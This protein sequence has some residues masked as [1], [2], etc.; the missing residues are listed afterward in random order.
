MKRRTMFVASWKANMGT[1]EQAT[2]FFDE[3]APIS[4]SF[5]HEVILCPNHVFIDMASKKMP[6]TMQLGAQD[7]SATGNGPHTGE[8]TASVLSNFGVK[9]AIVGHMERRIA[10]EDDKAVNKKIKQCLA[11]GIR[12]IITVGETLAE[13]ER[14]M[15]RVILERQ[16][17]EALDG[18]REYDK[19]IFC[20]QPSWSIGTGHFTSGDYTNLIMDFMRKHIQKLT[21]Q[22]MAGNVPMLYGGGV[23]V[24]NAREYLEQ[25]EVDG[26]MWG[27]NTTTAKGLADMVNLQFVPKGRL[28]S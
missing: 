14:N 9:Y 26:L 8:I 20:Y 12:P 17:M 15:T 22:P 28:Q 13:Y 3:I 5:M 25:P 24:N 21:G 4:A 18:V 16:L 11:A 1:Q 2:K 27:L 19:L 10:G 6:H 7:V 23:T